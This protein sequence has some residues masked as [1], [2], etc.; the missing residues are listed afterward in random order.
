M[1]INKQYTIDANFDYSSPFLNFLAVSPSIPPLYLTL[2]W[3][4]SDVR[5]A[6]SF[7]AAFLAA[8]LCDCFPVDEEFFFFFDHVPPP[9]TKPAFL[10]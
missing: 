2:F 9:P 1:L 7:V 5:F 4:A 3:F 10:G 8:S 6:D